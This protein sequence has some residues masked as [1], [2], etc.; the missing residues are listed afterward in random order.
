MEMEYS[1][2]TTVD[3]QRTTQRYIYIYIY[4]YIKM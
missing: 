3:F 4:I 2:E 1:S